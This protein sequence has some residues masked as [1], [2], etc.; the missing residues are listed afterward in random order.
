[1]G[2]VPAAASFGT[3]QIGPLIGR[4][5]SRAVGEDSMRI[6]EVGDCTEERALTAAAP[7]NHVTLSPHSIS[8][9]RPLHSKQFSLDV[10]QHRG[11][12]SEEHATNNSKGF[13]A[14]VSTTIPKSMVDSS[15]ALERILELNERPKYHYCRHTYITLLFRSQL[16][17]ISTNP[18]LHPGSK[19]QRPLTAS[20][21]TP[22]ARPCPSYQNF[23]C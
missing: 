12:P 19:F 3:L 21:H 22:N 14:H 8:S 20:T 9:A 1:M 4:R 7:A 13:T 17:Q 16:S 23:R 6:C 5:W 15:H 10:Y 18:T 2:G 11:Q